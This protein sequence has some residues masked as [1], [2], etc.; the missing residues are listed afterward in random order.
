M[1]VGRLPEPVVQVMQQLHADAF[2]DVPHLL[3]A[4]DGQAHCHGVLL[5]LC[6]YGYW[7][8]FVNLGRVTDRSSKSP[9]LITSEDLRG[10]K[11]CSPVM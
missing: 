3:C 8:G 5:V 4:H 7:C 2:V 6:I 9:Y 1:Q 10:L 11:H